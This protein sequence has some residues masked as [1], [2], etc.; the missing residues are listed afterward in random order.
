MAELHP[1]L[2]RPLT[3]A[4][5][6]EHEMLRLLATVLPDGHHVYHGMQTSNLHEGEQR[7]GELDAVVVFPS[8]HLA[9]LEVKAGEVDFSERGVFKRYGSDEKNIANQAHAQ[10]RGLIGG[11]RSEGLGKVHIAHFLL[12][13]DFRVMTGGIGYPRERI[14]DASQLDQIPEILAGVNVDP[15]LSAVELGQLHNFLANRFAVVPDSACRQGH[16][17]IATLRL[18]EGLATW[19]PRIQSQAGIYVVEA[20]AG[21]GKTQLALALLQNAAATAQRSR[22]VCFNRPLADH[23]IRMVSPRVDVSTIH[24]LAIDAL[25]A[26]DTAP[27]FSDSGTFERGFDA[28]RAANKQITPNVDLLIIDEAQDFD[29]E[30][31]EALLPRLKPDGR[32]YL[33]GDPDQAIYKKEPFE[34]PEAVRVICRDNFRSPRRIVDTVNLLKLV[35]QPI[36]AKGVEAGEEPSLHVHAADD[37][38]GLACASAI[39]DRLVR[40]GCSFEDISVLSFRGRERSR[41]LNGERLG[42]HSLKRFT[43]AFD[44]S[45]NALWSDG[46][47]LAESV[48][49]F[50]GQSAPVI[51]VCEIDFA[52]VDELSARKL[53][54]A[55]TRAQTQLHLVL[56]AAAEK[57]LLE[58]LQ[59]DDLD[60][61]EA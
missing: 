27:A 33:M 58:R 10:L 45:G 50:K 17:R 57:A 35:P 22:Y 6:R 13:P 11:L 31:L 32:L 3:L 43:G 2:S 28:M 38:G 47:L 19:V 12:L 49:R 36:V 30:W 54:V 1:E 16:L 7:Y 40:E 39:V 24:E 29:G 34:L 21:S 26:T 25:R 8:G 44:L 59:A 37:L 23:I 20:T 18:S 14:I 61:L 51:I 60:T 15:P 9:I 55:M 41:L 46:D 52:V 48:Y 42:S 4:Q 5:Y 53:F 56:S